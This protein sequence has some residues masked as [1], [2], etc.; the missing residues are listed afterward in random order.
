[1]SPVYDDPNKKLPPDEDTEIVL[2]DYD[3]SKNV[4][5]LER[6]RW[7]ELFKIYRAYSKKPKEDL[8]RS[9]LMIPLVASHIESYAPRLGRPRIDV[10]GDRPG[11]AERARQH[12]A[13]QYH[14]WDANTMQ[15]RVI[16]F[17]KSAHIYG[18]AWLKVVFRKEMGKRA[19]R[20][21]P[22]RFLTAQNGIL[23]VNPILQFFGLGGGQG[24]SPIVSPQGG[25]TTKEVELWNGAWIAFPEVDEI[26]PDFGHS[27]LDLQRFI[28]HKTQISLA[29]LENATEDGKPLYNQ[30][31]VAELKEL[32]KRG[33]LFQDDREN[34]K[35]DREATF[36]P[37]HEPHHDP[38]ARDFTLIEH[39]TNSKV[40]CVIDEAHQLGCIRNDTNKLGMKPFALY[41][42]TPLP[43]EL[44]G[45]STAEM[46][47]AIA[48]EMSGIHNAR[49]DSMM[50]AVH[51]MYSVRKGSGVNPKTIRWR[52]GG[53]FFVDDHDDIAPVPVKGLDFSLYRESD[54]LRLVAQ[55]ISGSTDTFRGINTDVSGD[56]ATEASLLSQAGASRFG[57]MAQILGTQTFNRMGKILMKINELYLDGERF[58]R[59][60][61][62][63]D[64]EPIK[65]DPAELASGDGAELGLSFD[66]SVSDPQNRQMKLKR[67]LETLQ[68]LG[69]TLPP[70]DPAFDEVLIQVLDGLDV[71]DPEGVVQRRRQFMEQM[72][73]AQQA[74]SAAPNGADTQGQDIAALLGGDQGGL[75]VS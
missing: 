63:P 8:H 2:D 62:R 66:I 3:R 42:P 61:G 1:M 51:Q 10:W 38:Y 49:Y 26:F 43:N 39:W 67:G 7:D 17:F 13:L 52:P 20:N 22:N 74:Q 28:I 31:K 27:D 41:T 37:T 34:L 32:A 71:T 70:Q 48:I 40:R 60:T 18:A 45:W 64:E 33:N 21:R 44:Y 68:I 9:N 65:I 69:Q 35:K 6:P 30:S 12:R 56:T 53:Y 24:A 25:F 54:Y 46:L 29:T 19:V 11:D 73:A 47:Y 4:V 55:E 57:L 16:P 5:R 15:F 14:D 23:P 59:V 50:Q 75:S 72:I 58:A 36:G